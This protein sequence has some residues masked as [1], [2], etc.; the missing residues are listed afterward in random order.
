M[1]YSCILYLSAFVV[2][3]FQVQSKTESQDD[4]SA[5]SQQPR[6]DNP[7]LHRVGTRLAHCNV[8]VVCTTKSIYDFSSVKILNCKSSEQQHLLRHITDMKL[9]KIL[10]SMTPPS[11]S[12]LSQLIGKALIKSLKLTLMSSYSHGGRAQSLGSV[13][14]LCK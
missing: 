2:C 11:F 14:P 6:A 1:F 3:F 9:R 4:C 12:A 10:R 13:F 7:H 8:L 5:T